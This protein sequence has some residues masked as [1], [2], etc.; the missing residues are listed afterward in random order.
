MHLTTQEPEEKRISAAPESV[1]Y[2]G[3]PE[4]GQRRGPR[5]SHVARNGNSTAP[6]LWGLGSATT[7]KGTASVVPQDVKGRTQ[8]AEEAF[9]ACSR[10]R[11]R[12]RDLRA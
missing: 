3:T 5:A 2:R 7:G 1:C 8:P 10:P 6:P 11:R 4:S 12:S 9:R